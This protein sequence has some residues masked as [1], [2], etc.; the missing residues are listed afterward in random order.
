MLVNSK[1][2]INTENILDSISVLTLCQYVALP[3]LVLLQ[4]QVLPS[5]LH[6]SFTKGFEW[7]SVVMFLAPWG[8]LFHPIDFQ[9]APYWVWYLDDN[10]LVLLFKPNLWWEIVLI[11]KSLPRRP[12]FHWHTNL[13]YKKK[14]KIKITFNNLYLIL[15]HSNSFSQTF[16]KVLLFIE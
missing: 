13:S 4:L 7:I 3:P 16:H 10:L 15:K 8:P 5:Y 12:K 1:V 14:K 6:F 9:M 2:K 11:Y